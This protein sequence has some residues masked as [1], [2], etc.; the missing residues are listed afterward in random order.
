M[1]LRIGEEIKTIGFMEGIP[2]HS[3]MKKLT[4]P[5]LLVQNIHPQC[6][7]IKVVCGAI[8][9]LPCGRLIFAFF[10]FFLTDPL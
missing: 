8:D 10:F 1:E 7:N 3:Q 6:V 9:T 5:N 2:C 4:S